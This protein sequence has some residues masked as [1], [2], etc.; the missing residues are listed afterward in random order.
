MNTKQILLIICSTALAIPSFSKG[1]TQP[2]R[3][4]QVTDENIPANDSVTDFDGNV[5]RTVTIGNQVWLRE[6]LKTTHFRNGDRIPTTSPAFRDISQDTEPA[7]QWP[8]GGDETNAPEY[9][10]LYTFYVVS[11]PR[12]V[13]P[14]GWHVPSLSEWQALI[15]HLGTSHEAGGKI[16]ASGFSHW[17]EPNSGATNETGFTALPGGSRNEDGSFRNLGEFGSWWTSSP[18]D[19]GANYFYIEHDAPNIFRTYIYQSKLYG[20]SVRCIKD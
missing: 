18:S 3:P 9:G 20:F 4:V 19:R 16:K 2:E 10:R 13:C 7:F 5:Y 17:N 1:F 11:D 12:G 14:S 15:N 6:N 8:Y